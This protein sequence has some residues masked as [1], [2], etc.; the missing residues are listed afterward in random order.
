[1]RIQCPGC[2]ARYEVPEARLAP[3]RPVRCARCAR[4][5]LPMPVP[6]DT[7]PPPEA[8]AFTEPEPEAAQPEEASRRPH[9]FVLAP[10]PAELVG[11]VPLRDFLPVTDTGSRQSRAVLAAWIVSVALVAA[12]LA[13]AV[14]LRDPISRAWPPSL[15]VYEALRLP[16]DD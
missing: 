3:G 13:A 6:M 16:V 10:R 9:P 15:R 8:P 12:A 14:V 7:A 11:D 1:M 4:D 5:W 2:G